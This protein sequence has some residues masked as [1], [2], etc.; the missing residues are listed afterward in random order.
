MFSVWHP[1]PGRQYAI[2]CLGDIIHVY[3][4]LTCYNEWPQ[5][6]AG[7]VKIQLPWQLDRAAKFCMAILGGGEAN[8]CECQITSF[9]FPF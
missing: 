1:L 4:W 7:V 3:C 6:S 5:T 8:E 9:P 2:G